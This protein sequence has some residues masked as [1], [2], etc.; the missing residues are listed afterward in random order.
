[1]VFNFSK[2]E[3]GGNLKSR[4]R[5]RTF[6]RSMYCFGNFKNVFGFK[7]FIIANLQADQLKR[8]SGVV[9]KAFRENLQ[10]Q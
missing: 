9:V 7:S 3:S 6:L 2:R 1:M 5:L 10:G 8:S 4:V